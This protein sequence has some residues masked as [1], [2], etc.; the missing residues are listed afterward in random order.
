MYCILVSAAYPLRGGIAH[1]SALLARTLREHHRVEI[2]TFKR[3]YPSLLFPGTSQEESGP[4][5]D[6]AP[7]PQL[8]DS[9]N[10]INWVRVGDELRRRSPDLVI[11]NYWMPFFGPCFGTIASRLRR[12]G[13]TRVFFL[14]HNVLP[15]EARPFDRAFTRY[16]LSRGDAFIV[17]SETVRRDLLTIVPDARYRIV[18]HPVYS[19]FGSAIPKE[20][21]RARLDL[22]ARR[23]VLFFGYVRRY[24]GL[25]ILL[26]AV[27]RARR[28]V[29]LDLLVVGEFYDD[30]SRYRRLIQEL[31]LT[32]NVRIVSAYVPNEHVT[33]YFSAADCVVLPYLSA[34]QSG[35]AQIAYNFD[36]PVIATDVGG[37]AEVVHDGRNGYVVPAG[38][39]GALARALV[40]FYREDR[41]EEFAQNVQQDKHAYSWERL[42]GAIE[43]LASEL[44]SEGEHRR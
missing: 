29:D 17:Q 31:D 35:I 6:E 2:V 22:S 28:D 40:Q 27:A 24:K 19:L 32:S 14:L 8:I 44:A 34:T 43:E 9:I 37:L 1:Y 13:S 39:V 10:P 21:A 5:L 33:L 42:R 18:P 11:F 36:T 26:Q 7:A 30:E 38:D 41:A 4:A 15:H 12:T 20:E 23:V 3:Q 16:A 25:D